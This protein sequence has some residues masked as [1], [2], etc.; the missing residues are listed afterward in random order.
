LNI[1]KSDFLAGLEVALLTVPQ[2][3]AYALVA[4][5]PI[6]TGLFA[7][8]FSAIIAAIMGSSR[9]LIVGPVNAIAILVQAGTADILHTYYRD[10]SG[11]QKDVYALEIMTQIALLAGILHLLVAA[12]KLGRM[13]QFVSHSVVVGYLAG[14]ALAIITNQLFT[15]AGIPALPGVNSLYEKLLYF[16]S[17][18]ELINLPTIGVGLGSL[19]LLLGLKKLSKRLPSAAIMLL[20][21]GG[22]CYLVGMT[23]FAHYS[24]PIALIGSSSDPF[25]MIP[26]FSW[27]Y[28]NLGIMNHMIAVAFA[29]ALLSII[30]TTCSAKSIAA[31]SGQGI[32]INQEILSVGAANLVSSCT[33]SM[34]VSVSNSRSQLN[35]QSGA[36]TRFAAIFSAI[37]VAAIAGYLGT[38]VNLIPLSALSALLFT[39]A[40]TL[41]NPKQLLLCVKSTSSDA[42]VLITTFFACVFF[43]LDTAFYIGVVLSISLYLKKAAMPQLMEYEIQDNGDLRRLHLSEAYLQKLIRVIKVEGELFFGSADIF[44]TTLKTLAEDDKTTR[45]IL[46]QLKNARDIDATSCLAL[47][48]LH[49]Y[50]EK[51]ERHLVLCGMTHEMW[52][53]MSNSGLIGTIGK[54]NLFVF[55]ER[56]PLL[57]MQKAIARAKKLAEE[58][59]KAIAKPALDI[60]LEPTA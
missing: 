7:A 6:S 36:Q 4:G 33:G 2:A 47:L 60:A 41:V 25:E 38:F 56:S 26:L 55:D 49:E 5:L 51:G 19:A 40:F 18:I 48:Q 13:T 46:L 10:A 54:D 37:L 50:L 30:E 20:I 28:F 17:H 34:P 53:V 44:Y 59:P 29:V 23:P 24:E 1:L 42:F 45:V 8:V 22:I 32:S 21:A 58:T 14:G 35:L 3:I 31:S 39:T 16:A 9:Y 27:P 12:F 15:F 52:D 57:Y 43:N 11:I